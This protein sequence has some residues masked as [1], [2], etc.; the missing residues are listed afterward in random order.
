MKKGPSSPTKQNRYSYLLCAALLLS[1][2]GSQVTPAQATPGVVTT[3]TTITNGQQDPAPIIDGSDFASDLDK[4]DL[5]VDVG[6]TGLEYD[7][8]A[9]VSTSKIRVNLHGTAKTG[10]I[11]ITVNTSAYAAAGTTTSNVLTLSV[12]VPMVNQYINLAAFLP[13]I[14]GETDQTIKATSSSGLQ[15]TIS[16]NTPSVCTIDFAKIHAVS[17]GT[18]SIKA[19][20]TGDTI[21]NAAP[22]LTRTLTVTAKNTPA[23]Q[24][25]P[26]PE[27]AT[28]LGSMNYDPQNPAGGYKSIL[29]T[30]SQFAHA[31]IL[32]LQLPP[33]ATPSTT[34]FLVSAS[35]TAKENAAGYFTARILGIT[36]D[37]TVVKKL[38]KPIEINIPQG[39]VD[40]LL[41]WSFDGKHWYQLSIL[42]SKALPANL[43]T[44]YF[45]GEDTRISILTD[46]LMLF[47]LRKPQLP[48]TVLSPVTKLNLQTTAALKTAGGSGEG[49]V[50][51]AT[52][53]EDICSLTPQGVVK[54]L[55]V[56]SC[57]ITATK[58]ASANLADTKSIV[59][60]LPITAQAATSGKTTPPLTTGQFA[61]GLL[62][63]A[64]TFL[65]ENG[66]KTLEVSLCSIYANEQAKLYLGSK[67]KKGSWK[68]SQIST[69]LLDENGVGNFTLKTTLP[70]NGRVRILVNGV[71]QM[72]SDL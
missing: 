20:Q 69:T 35:S 58:A 44:G 27:V 54:A 14:V 13:M 5:T 6:D 52:S 60:S 56:G 68:W 67:T 59:F 30:N 43:H 64:L 15:V 31:I 7:S 11:I 25:T 34:V 42:T 10:S 19:Q 37:G 18:C 53:T 46:Y 41:Y 63:H 28:E 70:T 50:E 55:S 8:V 49:A 17:A 48:L 32:K 12:P 21:Y 33:E 65:T 62:T 72:E 40:A 23:P 2:L 3:Q 39:A 16:S 45:I 26:R 71:I 4:F 22:T 57:L 47:G 24:V 29:V 66:L 51:Y 61:T 1:I 36:S 9:F 38:D